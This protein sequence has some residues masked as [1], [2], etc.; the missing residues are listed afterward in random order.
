MRPSLLLLL[1]VTHRRALPCTA[2]GWH[3]KS[4]PRASQQEHWQSFCWHFSARHHKA[5]LRTQNWSTTNL[6]WLA[7]ARVAEFLFSNSNCFCLVTNSYPCYLSA[8]CPLS[9]LWARWEPDQRWETGSTHW[10]HQWHLR[11]RL[12]WEH[13]RSWWTMESWLDSITWYGFH[14]TGLREDI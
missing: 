2:V 6:F 11:E 4:P 9:S 10:V 13:Y 12:V 3:S 5:C 1:T 8:V 7:G 14:I